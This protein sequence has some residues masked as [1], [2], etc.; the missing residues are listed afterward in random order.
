MSWAP[1]LKRV[2][3]IDITTCPQCNRPL[4]LIA[5][6]E[7]PAVIVKI[8]RHLRLPARPPPKAPAR[9]DEFLPNPT[10]DS[11][12]MTVPTRSLCPFPYWGC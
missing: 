10:L 8:L 1:L 4:T 2:F 11:G 9:L 5:A 12:S 6:I 3:P 7:E